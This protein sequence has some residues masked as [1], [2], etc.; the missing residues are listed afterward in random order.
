MQI[1]KFSQ[2]LIPLVSSAW[3]WTRLAV[4]VGIY[5]SKWA[6]HRG[7]FLALMSKSETA[8][9]ALLIVKN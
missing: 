8:S 6:V 4:T 5:S 2:Q 9:E 1:Q 7:L 3:V